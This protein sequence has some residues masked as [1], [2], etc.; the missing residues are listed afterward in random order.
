MAPSRGSGGSDDGGDSYSNSSGTGKSRGSSSS[1]EDEIRDSGGCFTNA[2]ELASRY[3]KVFKN[4][5]KA[6]ADTW[7]IVNAA[8]D[9][10][11]QSFK[12]VR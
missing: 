4:I 12:N 10:I 1:E 8:F 6:R 5:K 3:T 11:P 9:G 7:S 2:E